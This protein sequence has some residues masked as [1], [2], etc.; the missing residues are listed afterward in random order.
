MDGLSDSNP[1]TQKEG[2]GM[3]CPIVTPTERDER[4]QIRRGVVCKV[5]KFIQT[6]QLKIQRICLK[7]LDDDPTNRR[8]L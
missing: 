8:H 2:G 1:D 5:P 7:D 4:K 6:L 3:V